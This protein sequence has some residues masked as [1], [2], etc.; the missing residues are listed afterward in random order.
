MDKIDHGKATCIVSHCKYLTKG[1][2]YKLRRHPV[3]GIHVKDDS[4]GCSSY[5]KLNFMLEPNK[6]NIDKKITFK[7]GEVLHISRNTA[8]C[9]AELLLEDEVPKYIQVADADNDSLI[10]FINISEILYIN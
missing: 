10:Q 6:N 1:K 2:S 8:E 3:N 5:S 7:G 4:G 9:V